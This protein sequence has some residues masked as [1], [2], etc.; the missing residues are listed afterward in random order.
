MYANINGTKLY[1]DINGSG[2]VIENGL[3]KNKPVVFLLHG[4]PGGT[5]L[6]FKPYLNELSNKVQ[7]VYIDQRGCG[8]SADEDP[9]SYTLENNVEDLEALREHL[10]LS[11]IWVLGHS[12]GGMVAM[13]YALKYQDNLS[14]LLLITTSPSYRF[15]EKAKQ[16]VEKEGNEEQKFYAEKLWNGNFQSYEELQQYYKVMDS[17]YSIK[18]QN[19]ENLS[20]PKVKRSYEALNK[21]FGDFLRT[22]DIVDKLNNIKIPTL[23]IAGKHDWITP[24]SEN[25]TIHEKISDSSFYILE[26]SSHNVFADEQDKFN[27]I[28]SEFLTENNN[29]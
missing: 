20:R 5:H 13:S 26:N 28:V 22:F 9:E 23:I 4:G 16:Y 21:G 3:V 17:L 7:L 24:V 25:H 18:S 6:S 2:K 29:K 19:K 27:K 15:I 12:Y 8:S 10:G 11:K 14:G 1:F